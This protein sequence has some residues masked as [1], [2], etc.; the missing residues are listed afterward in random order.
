MIWYTVIYIHS[1]L[2][3]RL[4]NT[5]F[6]FFKP[7]VHP[8][9]PYL[10][11]LLKFTFGFTGTIPIPRFG[12]VPISFQPTRVG[13]PNSSCNPSQFANFLEPNVR[14]VHNEAL[15]LV[16]KD[17]E[18]QEFSEE[19]FFLRYHSLVRSVKVTGNLEESHRLVSGVLES[20]ESDGSLSS[21]RSQRDLSEDGSQCESIDSERSRSAMSNSS[22]F[23]SHFSYGDLE[24]CDGE[25]SSSSQDAASVTSPIDL[26]PVQ[27]TKR[28]VGSVRPNDFDSG[29]LSQMLLRD[30]ERRRKEFS[31][32]TTENS[33]RP[34]IPLGMAKA[35]NTA[36]EFGFAG[37]LTTEEAGMSILNS[38][39]F[40]VE[41]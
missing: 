37:R 17:H 39:M 9:A 13:R 5:K 7:D 10:Y 23:D 4:M 24:F 6:A 28:H 31:E 27:G 38:F 21:E 41:R 1:S 26:S 36:S 16:F 20:D 8:V 15:A 40:W 32:L 19:N 11:H 29:V 14:T 12:F 2:L 34:N 30:R 33:L 25:E 35:T 22:G 3:N 18:V